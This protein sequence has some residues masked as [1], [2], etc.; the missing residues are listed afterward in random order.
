MEFI[1]YQDHLFKTT[2]SK[3]QVEFY[4]RNEINPILLELVYARNIVGL[5]N[6]LMNG[7]SPYGLSGER[8]RMGILIHALPRDIRD[9]VAFEMFI[10]LL[11]YSEVDIVES[12]DYNTNPVQFVLGGYHG[13]DTGNMIL[14]IMYK[15]GYRNIVSSRIDKRTNLLANL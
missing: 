3:Y 5:H 1:K 13:F 2:Y 14:Q 10:M 11:N 4:G 6:Y 7:N 8:T 9:K 15:K 12:F